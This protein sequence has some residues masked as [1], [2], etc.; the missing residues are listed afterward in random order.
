MLGGSARV[1][2]CA[3]AWS[4]QDRKKGSKEQLVVVHSAM[5]AA[6][7]AVLRERP[8]VGDALLVPS[9][10]DPSRS[11]QRHAATNWVLEG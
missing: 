8:T 3:Q 7:V 9:L 5:R 4:A 2:P 1:A 11:I 10:I 6:L